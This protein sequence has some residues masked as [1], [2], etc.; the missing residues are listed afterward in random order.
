MIIKIKQRRF[1][2]LH[3]ATNMLPDISHYMYSKVY[4]YIC[5]LYNVQNQINLDNFTLVVI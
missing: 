3:E 5:L 4:H 2:D 1:G